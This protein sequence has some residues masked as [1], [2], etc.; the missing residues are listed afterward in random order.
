M[1][2]NVHTGTKS[3]RTNTPCQTEHGIWAYNLGCK[4]SDRLSFSQISD[5]QL[6]RYQEKLFKF[7]MVERIEQLL[8]ICK[9]F[10]V[11]LVDVEE[12]EEKLN[13]SKCK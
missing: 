3:N 13:R 11:S 1:L 9:K 5:N 4:D 6:F 7:L 10:V 2:Y 8:L 12:E